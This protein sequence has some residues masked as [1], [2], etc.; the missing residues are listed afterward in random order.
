MT[1]QVTHSNI[2]R[3]FRSL[4]FSLCETRLV[5]VLIYISRLYRV[6]QLQDRTVAGDH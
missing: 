5:L 3:K 1:Q 6:F 2:R 4:N